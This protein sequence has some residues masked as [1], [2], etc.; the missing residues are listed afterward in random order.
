MGFATEIGLIRDIKAP[1]DNKMTIVV[2]KIIDESFL[3]D[4]LLQFPA[5][6]QLANI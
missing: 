5:V 2:F 4:Y 3:D 1:N 6:S